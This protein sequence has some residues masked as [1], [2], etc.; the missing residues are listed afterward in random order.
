MLGGFDYLCS[1]I[2]SVLLALFGMILSVSLYGQ[3]YGGLVGLTLVT[4]KLPEGLEYA[5][6]K[7]MGQL[8]YP[9]R[10]KR[11]SG[12]E[13]R[14]R[15]IVEPQFNWVF[16]PVR[17]GL[18]GIERQRAY[19]FGANAGIRY[20]LPVAPSWSLHAQI[21]AGPH[22]ISRAYVQQAGGYIFS[23][24]FALGT[25]VTL[26]PGVDLLVQG[27]FRH[28]SNAGLQNPNKGLDNF[29]LMLGL[30]VE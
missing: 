9:L 11:F 14:W 22:Y 15:V 25:E 16:L 18:T 5:P 12:N 8:E 6:L 4:E 3:R 24:N 27:R 19:E 1:M 13:A 10:T 17:E 7:F 26:R 30:I 28:L 20:R 21:S 2:R 29:F 23:D